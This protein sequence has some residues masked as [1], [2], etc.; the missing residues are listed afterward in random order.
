V[1]FTLE[2]IPRRTLIGLTLLLAACIVGYALIWSAGPPIADAGL[3]AE[4]QARYQRAQ[5]A[6]DTAAVDALH[7]LQPSRASADRVRCGTLR[8]AGRI[9]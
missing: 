2:E 8:N 7:P 6:G 1:D 9:P 3:I 5:T 4:C